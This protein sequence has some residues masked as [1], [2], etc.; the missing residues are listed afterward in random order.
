[1]TRSFSGTGIV[2]RVAPLAE[3]DRFV[4]FYTKEHGK[5]TT[6][7][8]GI[9]S[10]KSR[11]SPHIELMNRVKFQYWRSK[12]HLYLTQAQSE[13]HFRDLKHEMVSL[14][15]GAFMIEALERLTPDEEPNLALFDLLNQTLE[16]MN[17]Y[18]H[19]HVE[20][21]EAFLIKLLQMLGHITGFRTCSQCH[22]KLPQATAYL[23]RTHC[24]LTCEP[25]AQKIDAIHYEKVPLG[26]LKLM[27][28]ILEHPIHAVLKVKT[29]AT[30]INLMTNF[31]RV[32]LAQ[33]LQY[34]LKSERSLTIY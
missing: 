33:I 4:T 30:H 9:R 14:A 17:F 31:G 22:Q 29:E 19:K 24:T 10:V 15:S 16:V 20:L 12:H 21:R 13:E 26:A 2:I 34:P 7:A 27:H 23:N 5:L 25:C 6:I 8:K 18:P 3:S 28:F 11:R 1:M 32:F